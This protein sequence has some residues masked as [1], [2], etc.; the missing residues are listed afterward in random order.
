M[1]WNRDRQ[2]PLSKSAPDDQEL[3]FARVREVE[4]KLRKSLAIFREHLDELEAEIAQ[5][6]RPDEEV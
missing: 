4:A 5:S 3:V 2:T 6:R 1:I